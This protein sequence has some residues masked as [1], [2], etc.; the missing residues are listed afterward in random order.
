NLLSELHDYGFSLINDD[1]VERACALMESL[2]KDRIPTFQWQQVGDLRYNFVNTILK[3]EAENLLGYGPVSADPTSGEIIS[4]T[5]NI[6]LANITD[7]AVNSAI[8]M[9]EL[10]RLQGAD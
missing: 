10:E 6:Y 2:T 5:A 3:P 7:Y 1:N 9:A 8:R 4:S